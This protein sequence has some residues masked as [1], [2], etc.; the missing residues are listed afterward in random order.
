M[1]DG[2]HKMRRTIKTILAAIGVISLL[3]LAFRLLGDA[4]A[5]GYAESARRMFGSPEAIRDLSQL[6]S[7]V[8][9]SRDDPTFKAL[10][11][12]P[13]PTKTRKVPSAWLPKRFSVPWGLWHDPD[14]IE[15]GDV[16]AYY[17]TS[18]ELVAIEFLGSRYGCF[19][20]RDAQRCPSYFVTLHRLAKEP[21]FVTAVVSAD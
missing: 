6:Y 18:D 9:A 21:V 7:R 12:K 17:D 10:P 20:S 19:I 16:L 1:T 5:P 11:Q 3:L 8:E 13:Y 14:R 2:G 4:F 15:N